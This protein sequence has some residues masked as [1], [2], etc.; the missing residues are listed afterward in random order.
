MPSRRSPRCLVLCL[1]AVMMAAPALWAQT[2][3]PFVQTVV[4]KG[5]PLDMIIVPGRPPAWRMPAVK[6]PRL[7][8]K[9]LS[10]IANVPALD[11]SYGCSA[12]SAAMIFGYYDNAGYPDMYSG[13]TNGGVFPQTNAVWGPGQCPLS[14]TRNG[15]DGRTGRGHVDDYYVA[16]N[17]AGP[18]PWISNRWVQHA[19]SDCTGDYMGTNQSAFSNV[20]G[21][22]TFFYYPEGGPCYDYSGDEPTYR[23]GAHGLKLFAQSRGYTVVTVYNQY[24]V[25][26]NG[27][28]EGFS[29]ADFKAEID[30]GRP[31]LIQVEGH[32]MVGLGYDDAAQTVYIHDTWDYS[33]HTMIWG[34]TYSGMAHYGVT[35][36]RLAPVGNRPPSVPQSLTI[37]PASPTCTSVLVATASGA[38]D[39][40]GTTPTYKYQWGQFTGGPVTWGH[41]STDGTL[42]GVTLHKG[43]VWAVHACATDGE[44]DSNWTD[45]T[46]VTIIDAAPVVST[47]TVTPL[48]PR[49]NSTLTAHATATDGDND[50]LTYTFQWR[51]YTGGAWSAWG[52]ES[53]D[54][55]LTGAA[56]MKG[57]QWQAQARAYDGTLYGDWQ[58]AAAVTVG[59]YPPLPPTTLT[60]SPPHPITTSTLRARAT[61]ASDADGDSLTCRYQWC[62]S[63]D[64]GGTW[65]AWGH[66]G[67][68]LPASQTVHGQQWRFRCRVSD[69]TAWSAWRVS[70]VVRIANSAPTKPKTVGV[71]PASPGPDQDLIASAS[72]SSDA[73]GDV[74]TYTC[75]W[76]RSKDGG[77]TWSAFLWDGATL[78]AA[79]TAKGDLWKMRAHAFDG[80][81]YSVYV[82]SAPVTIGATAGG[83]S[84]A[85]T[86]G[87]AAAP[88]KA[89][90][91]AVTVILSGAADVQLEICNLAGRLVASVPPQG[92]PGGLSTLLWNGYSVSGTMVPNGTYLLR[93]TARSPDGR[94][95]QSVSTLNLSR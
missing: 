59:N 53:T 24:I 94:Q 19:Y 60:L 2:P 10:T 93:V 75:Q 70:S 35:V 30:A 92:L 18:D 76:A 38:T 50:T 15:Y 67:V 64:N 49:Y 5:R 41:D 66:A 47:V 81:A 31:V 87:S 56:L 79:L 45:A 72:G 57:G 80:A 84:R 16:Y 82:E 37:S 43:D 65:S 6:L 86:L 23:D 42:S 13:P 61:G 17:N 83:L 34:G 77:Q 39:P 11:W 12:T 4:H 74:I 33:T 54:G 32:T 51:Q 62:S 44:R 25:G 85:L 69:G 40:D 68:V 1:L 26:W 46:Q 28:T 58:Q 27:N 91:V 48:T 3:R 36:L 14:A 7:H 71:S 95:C 29:F 90:G 78:S 8:T 73:D 52:Y 21:E 22:T 9:S 89:G 20:D 88:T 55:K 63:A